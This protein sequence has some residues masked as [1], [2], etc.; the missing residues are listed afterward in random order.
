MKLEDI[1]HIELEITTKCNARCPQC[2]RNYYGS[3]TWTKLPIL[4][5]SLDDFKKSMPKEIWKTL[6]QVK[7]CGT[8]GDP[9]MHKDLTKFIKYI[10]KQ[11]PNIVIHINTNGGI[12]SVAWWKDLA[13]MLGSNDKVYFG[14]D[15]LEDT[16]PLYRIDVDYWKVLDNLKAFNSAGGTSIWS[17][18]AFKH[19]EHQVEDARALSKELGCSDFVIKSTS[20]FVDKQ[21]NPVD[22]TPV[23]NAVYDV[24]YWLEPAVGQYRNS[25]YDEIDGIVEEHGSWEDYL[26]NTSIDC[27]SKRDGYTYVAANGEMFPCGFLS[28]RMYGAETEIHKDHK[29]MLDMFDQLGGRHKINIFETPMEEIVEKGWFPAIEKSWDTNLIQRCANQCGAKSNLV[30]MANNELK[31]TWSY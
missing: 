13:K 3:H 26:N 11:N 17:Y 8:Y 28:D 7:F 19:N 6:K 2:V 16:S 23:M 31:K 18:L 4:D 9:L 20:R 14:I 22:R 10:K 15:G 25:G 5:M 27:M 21:H 29:T 30:K 24:V 1:K 12:R